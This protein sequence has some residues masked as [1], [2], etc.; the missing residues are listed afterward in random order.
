MLRLSH[1]PQEKFAYRFAH[2]ATKQSDECSAKHRVRK[3]MQLAFA[4]MEAEMNT[5]EPIVPLTEEVAN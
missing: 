4:Q 2:P 1:Q 3:A 5:A